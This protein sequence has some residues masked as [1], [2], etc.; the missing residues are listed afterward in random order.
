M[1]TRWPGVCRSSPRAA[2]PAGQWAIKGV[3]MPP[4]CVKI[5]DLRSGALA[6]LAQGGS[7]QRKLL[8]EPGGADGIVAVAADELLGAGAVVA[9]EEDE[10][11]LPL[12]VLAQLREH[13]A[14]LAVHPVDHRGVNRHAPL[15]GVLLRGIERVPRGHAR[16]PLGEVAA[17]RSRA[18]ASVRAVAG[19]A[20]PSRP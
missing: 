7:R 14:D 15:P 9:G 5:F 20:H 11:V 8:A 12:A 4:S 10:G 17:R 19:G 1:S 6:R 3:E 13:A 2:R 16:G 18:A